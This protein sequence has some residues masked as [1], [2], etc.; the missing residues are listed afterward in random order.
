MLITVF[1]L[2]MLANFNGVSI[3]STALAAQVMLLLKVLQSSAQTRRAS[4][5][6]CVLIAGLKKLWRGC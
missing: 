2:A 6:V 4:Y 1:V 3:I 5:N